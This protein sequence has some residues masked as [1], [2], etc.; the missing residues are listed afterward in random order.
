MLKVSRKKK[1]ERREI[2]DM[3]S[4]RVLGKTFTIQGGVLQCRK[5]LKLKPP[6]EGY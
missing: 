4:N 2:G 3:D 5:D 1:P 6:N